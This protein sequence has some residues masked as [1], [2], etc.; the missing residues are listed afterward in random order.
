M[1]A[2][3]T[4]DRKAPGVYATE[5]AAFPT[6]IVGV[7]TAVP[8]FIGY[9][10]TAVDPA[11]GK[12][13]SMTPVMIQS[14]A[15]Y[16]AYFGGNYR[17]QFEVVTA[18]TGAPDFQADGAGYSVRATSSARFNM[19][20]ALEMFY[21][22]GGG[23]CTV[24][25]TGPYEQV[26]R[27]GLLDGLAAA[28]NQTGPTMLVVPDA[29]LLTGAG[30]YGAVATAQLNQAG[31]LGDRMAILDLPGALDPAG[32]T[33]DGLAAQ[34]DAFYAATAPADAYLGCGA[35]YAPAIQ[36]SVLGL[37]D[38]DF[39]NLQSSD[40]LTSL[41]TAQAN[42]VFGT[43]TSKAL[44]VLAKIDQVF[45]GSAVPSQDVA[46]LNAFL[47]NALP[48]YA[49]I[50]TIVLQKMNVA[51]PSAAM[52]GLWTLNDDTRGV[53]NA[54]ANVTVAGAV[55]PQVALSDAQRADYNMPENGKAIDILRDFPGRGTVVW[56]ARTLD[57]N[58]NDYRYI[59]V[60]RT[61]VY[62]ETSIKNALNPFAFAANDSQTWTTVTS[63]ISNFLTQVW[64]QGGLM[65]DK[66][67]DAF[68][69]Q[70]GVGSTMTPQDVL[71]GYMIVQVV[72][73]MIHP[74]EFIVLTI[75]QTMQG[76]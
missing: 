56:G 20:V 5:F 49:Q 58:S 7:A 8:I 53:W 3:G 70:C 12:S 6:S 23:S 30:D 75:K 71:N 21:A 50:E 51:A 42:A 31:T 14:M 55:A 52:A 43:G 16:G 61:L 13:L 46:A 69:V 4:K 45:G 10:E 66:A 62:I 24:V 57:G 74:A 44:Q 65:G 38:V 67:S 28:A 1:A 15:D 47:A 37:D 59:Q 73:Q 34:R 25:S 48:L 18:T 11:T 22:N 32:W 40:L 19:F 41:L 72:L 36:T 60:R 35:A 68:K 76:A 33:V 54:P 17:A 39:R 27:Q 63:M 29:C 64:S 2:T 26:A 9:T